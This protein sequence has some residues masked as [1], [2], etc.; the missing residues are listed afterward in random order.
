MGQNPHHLKSL[1]E[2]MIKLWLRGIPSDKENNQSQNIL[3]G[4]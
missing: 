1:F 2:N 3:G 4:A